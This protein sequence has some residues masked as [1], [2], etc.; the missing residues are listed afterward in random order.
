MGHARAMSTERTEPGPGATGTEFRHPYEPPRI[1]ATRKLTDAHVEALARSRI[2]VRTAGLGGV[3][4]ADHFTAYDF[5]VRAQGGLSGLLFRYWDPIQ[6]RFSK[7]FVRV[8]PDAPSPAA[9]YLQP[10]G[11]RPRLY[12]VA[13]TTA[14]ELGADTVPVFITEG[15]KK[16]L[17]LDRARLELGMDALVVGVGGVWS[18]RSSPKEL[19]P[20]GRLGK[21]KSQPIEDLD[22]IRWPARDVFL[23]FDSDV[24]TN[25]KVQAAE[26]ALASELHRRGARVRISRIPGGASWRK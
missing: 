11:E 8:K 3:E 16:A 7:R 19:Q 12:F 20:D 21:G 15:E 26:T 18:W 24:S 6:Q 22:W 25:W 17:A 2:D 23:I 4:S 10:V 5:G 1:V 14:S 13:G 9:K